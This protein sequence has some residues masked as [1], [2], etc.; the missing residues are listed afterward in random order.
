M[1]EFQS[2][3]AVLLGVFHNRL[4]DAMEAALNAGLHETYNR[5]ELTRKRVH[6]VLAE[7]IKEKK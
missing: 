7:R 4:Q 1:S 6:E 3:N 2:A 5:L